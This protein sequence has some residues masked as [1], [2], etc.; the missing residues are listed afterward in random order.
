MKARALKIG[1]AGQNVKR[2]LIISLATLLLLILCD[3]STLAQLTLGIAPTN[4]QA[5]LFWPTTD[6][7]TN[8]IL[9]STTNL[10]TPN[11]VSATDA[12]P[13]TYGTQTAVSVTNTSSARFFRLVLVPP[14]ADGMALIPAGVFTIGDT[15]DGESDAIPTNVY[16]SAFYM[17]VNLVSSNQWAAV[18]SYAT[19]H[20]YG[21]VN[22]GA[23]KA[24]NNPVQ[25]VDWYDCVKW[26]NARSQQAGLTPVYYTNAALTA[27]FTNGNGGTTV[28][29]NWTANGYRLPTE[30]E[31]EKAARGGLSGQRFPWGDTISESQANYYA[32]PNPPN[33]SGYTYDLGPYTGYNTN[34]VSGG[35]PTS[36]V[37][38]FAPNGYGLND[39]AGNVFE[40]CWDWY[41]GPTYPAGSPYLGGTDPRGP[42]GPL[43]D[44]VLRGGS[45]VNDAADARCA[46]RYIGNPVS[47]SSSGG[48]RCVRGL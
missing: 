36:P 26:S 41:A 33:P 27:V 16:V 13:V 10:A 42:V 25:T 31:W 47:T 20:G 38:Y 45:W 35:F 21:F 39:M 32:D 17:D 34:F 1:V 19:N 43:G 7:G 3:N 4:N 12:V 14:T 11:W 46:F 9:Q 29:A 15:L 6:N 2:H 18:Y 37:G 24:A 48:F 44:R 30:A 8:G 5:I 23:G 22:A 28:Y 40:W